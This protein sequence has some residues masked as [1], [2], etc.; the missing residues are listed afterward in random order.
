VLGK[1][2]LLFPVLCNQG[3]MYIMMLKI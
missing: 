2:L 1:T 3:G